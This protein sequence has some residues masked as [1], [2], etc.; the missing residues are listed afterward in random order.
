MNRTPNPLIEQ[1]AADLQPVRSI[2][3]KD[4]LILA[5]LTALVTVVAVELLQG[6]WRGAWAGEASAFFVI[7]NGLLLVLA[8]ASTSSVL[9]MAN[10]QVGNNR[11]GARWAMAMLAVLPIAALATLFGRDN[12]LAA[13]GEHHGLSCFGAGLAASLLSAAMLTLW[14]RRGAPVSPS[15]AGLLVGVASTALGAAAYGLACPL[16]DMVHLGI[17]H[18]APVLV[19]ALIGRVFLPPLLRW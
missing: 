2:R 1:M 3:F 6:L 14:L 7:T 16:D 9:K 17:W 15:S 4:G 8:C 10:P 19:G 11:E 13:L 12:P 18:V 5:V